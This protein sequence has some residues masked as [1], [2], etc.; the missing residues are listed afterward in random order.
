MTRWLQ[1]TRGTARKAV[2]ISLAVALLAPLGCAVGQTTPRAAMDGEHGLA[3]VVFL[4]PS[5][6]MATSNFSIVDELGNVIAR[7]GPESQ[8]ITDV[9]PGMRSFEL[10]ALGTTD[11]LGA[12]LVS[13][14]TYYVLV[15]VRTIADHEQWAFTALRSD[16]DWLSEVQAAARRTSSASDDEGVFDPV[17]VA[18]PAV[19]GPTDDEHTLRREDGR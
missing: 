9:A 17:R 11:R 10:R 6:E 14:K 13:G 16:R 12:D 3:R 15:S 18:W 7:V 4:R 19:A 2:G 8:A 1:T 5:P